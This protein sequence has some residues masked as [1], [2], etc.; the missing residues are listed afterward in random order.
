MK[1]SL[2]LMTCHTVSIHQSLARANN[3]VT[4]ILMSK[5]FQQLELTVCAFR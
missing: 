5:M 1:M 3:P 2:K 4:D